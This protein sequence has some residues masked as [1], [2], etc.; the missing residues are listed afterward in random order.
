MGF[1]DR[2]VIAVGCTNHC[3]N[4][5]ATWIQATKIT[6]V[7]RRCASATYHLYQFI[8]YPLKSN[9]P[10]T[11]GKTT[12]LLWV[13]SLWLVHPGAAVILAG[14]P[15]G[16][17]PACLKSQVDDFGLFRPW[18]LPKLNMKICCLII[19]SDE[20]A[21]KWAVLTISRQIWKTCFNW[22]AWNFNHPVETPTSWRL[23]EPKYWG[24]HHAS[25][26]PRRNGWAPTMAV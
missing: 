20:N 24:K 19:M 8:P 14:H 1:I 4:V 11:W 3:K 5:W 15:Y 17:S 18:N 7:L 25:F 2:Q 12:I 13:Q 9:K 10:C 6:K 16:K 26:F 22:T 21:D 23:P